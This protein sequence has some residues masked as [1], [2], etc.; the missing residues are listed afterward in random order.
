MK[1]TKMVRWV[2]AAVALILLASAC[3]GGVGDEAVG[4]DGDASVVDSEAGSA[5]SGESADIASA[6][7]GD[8]VE[9]AP[10][11][12]LS[13][14][15]SAP[16]TGPVGVRGECS[17]TR[18]VFFFGSSAADNNGASINLAIFAAANTVESAHFEPGDGSRWVFTEIEDLEATADRYFVSGQAED[19]NGRRD[20][21]PLSI[22]ILCR[23]PQ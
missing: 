5:D 16:G 9:V 14:L 4:T 12:A 7:S 22:T 17:A 19:L 18:G 6:D 23:A 15:A 8:F 21:G 11:Q 2:L 1:R 3:G 20:P 10:A 13:A